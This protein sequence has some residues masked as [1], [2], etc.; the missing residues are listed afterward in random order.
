MNHCYPK[1][2]W[3]QEPQENLNKQTNGVFGNIN[4]LLKENQAPKNQEHSQQMMENVNK[5][6]INNS[7]FDYSML[8][9]E[10]GFRFGDNL[11]LES[12]YNIFI[13]HRDLIFMYNFYILKLKFILFLRLL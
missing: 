2:E 9:P 13:I 5:N 10:L 4:Q 6:E 11:S 7:Y 12:D 3:N 1:I 8:V